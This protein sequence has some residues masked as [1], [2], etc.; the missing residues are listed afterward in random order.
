M[1][2]LEYKPPSTVIGGVV[3]FTAI[4]VVFFVFAFPL[5]EMAG[6][7]FQLIFLTFMAIFFAVPVLLLIRFKNAR[8]RV[9]SFMRDSSIGE[10][11][12][13]P[14]PVRYEVGTYTCTGE[15]RGS[16]K[17]RH[18][19][20][21]HTFRRAEIGEGP[22]ITLP[23]GP[24][25]ATVKQDDSGLIEFPAVRILSE[26][27][28][29]ILL[30]KMS[31][32]GAVN[33][34]GTVEVA[35]ENDSAQLSLRGAGKSLSGTVYATLQKARKAKVEIF[36]TAWQGNR[37]KI[38]EGIT[39]DFSKE[40]LP[41]GDTLIVAYDGFSPQDFRRLM[42]EG[43]YIMGHG[44]YGVRLILDIPFRPDVAEEGSFEVVLEEEKEEEREKGGGDGWGFE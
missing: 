3:V 13:L 36:H 23:E 22:T 29:N 34:S 25:I 33:A 31:S 21:S 9:S 27:Y 4:A 20:T 35:T 42:R 15:W 6:A 30:L 38:G 2:V 7:D 1:K 16:G 32:K 43:Q 26:P 8:S 11:V 24:F 40:L 17:N 10:T 19:Y 28:K 5:T 18:Y 12:T 44:V 41:E 14:Q 37:F 39:F